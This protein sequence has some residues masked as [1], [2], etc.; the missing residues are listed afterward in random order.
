MTEYETK[1]GRYYIQF[2]YI[3]K[4]FTN[5]NGVGHTWQELEIEI[6]DDYCIEYWSEDKGEYV[7]VMCD[8]AREVF[9]QY[10]GE[11]LDEVERLE[12]NKR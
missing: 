12:Q 7:Q 4:E 2:E 3:A 9:D 10:Y 6:Y 5:G 11:L 1:D 8:D